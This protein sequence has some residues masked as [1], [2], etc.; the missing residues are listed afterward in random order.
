MK[1]C[2]KT[3]F[4]TKG[5]HKILIFVALEFLS[6]ETVKTTEGFVDFDRPSYKPELFV[7]HV[8]TRPIG[9]LTEFY[10]WI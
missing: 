2:I 4:S 1:L 8:E 6:K 10:A 7:Q 5:K 9:E 3:N